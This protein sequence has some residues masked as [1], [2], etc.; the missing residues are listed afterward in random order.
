M[1]AA[2][3]PMALRPESLA[4]IRIALGYSQSA[5]ARKSGVS[6]SQISDI[7]A[8]DKQ[9][10]PATIHKLAQSLGVTIGALVTIYDL[11]TV[12]E[13]AKLLGAQPED[14]FP[15]PQHVVAVPA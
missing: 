11:E 15:Q 3:V 8:G 6:Q 13:A 4:A 1:S 12:R 7:E 5:L 14:I 9:A 10:S 2:L